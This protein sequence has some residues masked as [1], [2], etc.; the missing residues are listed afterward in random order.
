MPPGTA[1]A[2]LQ[3]DTVMQDRDMGDRKDMKA[4]YLSIWPFS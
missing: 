1:L 4:F 3:L 2:D